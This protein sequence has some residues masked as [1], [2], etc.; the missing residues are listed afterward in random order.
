MNQN[1]NL[2]LN[3]LECGDCI[4]FDGCCCINCLS[5][6]FGGDIICAVDCTEFEAF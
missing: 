5:N 4:H 3:E 2:N 1:K 6:N